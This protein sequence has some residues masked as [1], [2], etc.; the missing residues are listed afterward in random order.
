MKFSVANL[1]PIK[2]AEVTVAPLTIICGRNNTG[3]TYLTYS[4]FGLLD[5]LNSV[6]IYP[7]EDNVIDTLLNTG[8]AL[9]PLIPNQQTFNLMTQDCCEVFDKLIPLIFAADPKHF[10]N[11]KVKLSIDTDELILPRVINKRFRSGTSF[12]LTVSKTKDTKDISFSLVMDDNRDYELKALKELL[13]H[14]IG[15]TLK[16]IYLSHFTSNIMFAST[17]RTGILLFRDELTPTRGNNLTDAL[18]KEEIADIVENMASLIYPLPIGKNINLIKRLKSISLKESPLA[19]K[20]PELISEFEKISG[21]TYSVNDKGIFYIPNDS[22][23][24]ILSMEESSG[25]VRSLV[26]ISFWLKHLATKESLL[27]IDEPEMNLH[28]EGQRLL[29]RWIVMLMNYGVRVF[30]TTHSDYFVKEL[31][32]LIM[33]YTRRKKPYVTNLMKEHAISKDMM[34]SPSQIRIYVAERKTTKSQ[35]GEIKL[36]NTKL[37]EG[38]I[39]KEF[40]VEVSS[41]DN[42]IDSINNLQRHIL[43]NG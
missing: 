12:T 3:K 7:V 18:S 17:E 27:M 1:G 14:H 34:L 2:T 32:T 37:Y 35:S 28:P 9:L 43:F 11:T 23:S 4:F 33:L 31:N 38:R 21:G 16:Q 29:A 8:V 10:R 5:Y 24:T 22:K 41:F 39:H 25:S 26:M 30:I 20:H 6:G 36:D 13:K 42:T 19:R 40:G 15:V